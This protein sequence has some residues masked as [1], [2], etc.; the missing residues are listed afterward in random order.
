ML[1]VGA[2]PSACRRL[3]HCL[4]RSCPWH[5]W[6]VEGSLGIAS[7]TAIEFRVFF[8]NHD[9]AH[10][11]PSRMSRRMRTIIE[12]ASCM[13]V[14]DANLR[15]VRKMHDPAG[16]GTLGACQWRPGVRPCHSPSHR[17]HCPSRWCRCR[18]RR[19]RPLPAFFTRWTLSSPVWRLWDQS[20]RT[21]G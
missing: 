11:T 16:A 12:S 3:G 15:P 20:H 6:H 19:H 4:R 7:Q 9:G 1:H 8:G 17:R 10:P 14:K 2:E 21:S 13:P 5:D 18:Q